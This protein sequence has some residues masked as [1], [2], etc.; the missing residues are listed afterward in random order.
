MA[1][2]LK[3]EGR[4]YEASDLARAMFLEMQTIPWPPYGESF[5]DWEDMI[6]V[7]SKELMTLADAQ[8]GTENLLTYALHRGYTANHWGGPYY[9]ILPRIAYLARHLP[10]RL[11]EYDEDGMTPLM[12]ALTWGSMETVR[13][14]LERVPH[15]V[16]IDKGRQV[17][18]LLERVPHDVDIYKGRQLEPHVT[19]A[20]LAQEIQQTNICDEWK[21]LCTDVIDK[22]AWYRK[23]YVTAACQI[24]RSHALCARFLIDDLA[25]IIVLFLFNQ[26]YCNVG[27]KSSTDSKVTKS[28]ANNDEASGD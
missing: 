5:S 14:L 20:V 17:R 27:R 2:V 18:I 24:I 23:H 9:W 15:D 21:A 13:I 16:D 19:A 8:T 7:A 12:R 26:N 3:D 25:T 28:A 6:R 4:K 1:V 11:N 10:S 22:D